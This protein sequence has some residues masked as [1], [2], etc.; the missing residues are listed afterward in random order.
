MYISLINDYRAV[1]SCLRIESTIQHLKKE[2]NNNHKHHFQQ[3]FQ[4]NFRILKK[5]YESR[6]IMRGAVL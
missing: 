3:N 6:R 4:D 1:L 2:Q 5:N